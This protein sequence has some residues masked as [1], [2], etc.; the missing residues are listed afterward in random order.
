M[1]TTT[2]DAGVTEIG[3]AAGT[4]WHYLE[5]HGEMTLAQIRKGVSMSPDMITMAIGWLA[6]EGKIHF[7]QKGRVKK[8][9][10][11]V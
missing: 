2:Q 3:E 4:V 11:A 9:A 10:L 7:V 8:I 5:R 6:R 1:T